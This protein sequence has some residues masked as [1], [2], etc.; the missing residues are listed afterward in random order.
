MFTIARDIYYLALGI[1][2]MIFEVF[3]TIV[4]NYYYIFAALLA[5]LLAI[6]KLFF[7]VVERGRRDSR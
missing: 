1:I 2:V 4:K 7:E 3:I 6:Q 5:M